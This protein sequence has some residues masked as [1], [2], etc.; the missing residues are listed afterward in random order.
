MPREGRDAEY[1]DAVDDATELLREGSYEAALTQL[2]DIVKTSPEN[3]YAYYFI[4]V[5]LWE[6]KQLA[7][8][9]D[10]FR[11]AVHISPGYVGARASL[12]AVLHALGDEKG[13]IREGENALRV[14]PEDPDALYAVGQAFLSIGDRD[15]AVHYLERFLRTK[16]EYEV[17]VEVAE[18]LEMLKQTGAGAD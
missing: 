12:A 5:G 17:G 1:W 14:Q 16:P 7:P 8:A 6:L 2:R 11:A 3:P 10:A 18:T 15:S 13:A 9:R 4:G